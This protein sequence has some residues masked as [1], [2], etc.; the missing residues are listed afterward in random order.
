MIVSLH[1]FKRKKMTEIQ[2]NLRH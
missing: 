1:F 2:S